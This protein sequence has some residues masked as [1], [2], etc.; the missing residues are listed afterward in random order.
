M[1]R[2]G[3][4]AR[5]PLPCNFGLQDRAAVRRMTFAALAAASR[6]LSAYQQFLQLLGC[7]SG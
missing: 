1:K 4:I 7:K 2:G 5:W 3:A 6:D